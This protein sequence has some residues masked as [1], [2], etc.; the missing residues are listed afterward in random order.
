LVLVVAVAVE[1]N[2]FLAPLPK[3][4]LAAAVPACWI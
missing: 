2:K 4:G 3:P 1:T